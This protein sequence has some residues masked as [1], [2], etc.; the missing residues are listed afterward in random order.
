MKHCKQHWMLNTPIFKLILSCSLPILPAVFLLGAYDL[1]ETG[2]IARLCSTHLAALSFSA[3]VTTAMTGV[4]IAISIA[5]NSWICRIK[6]G[7]NQNSSSKDKDELQSNLVRSLVVA[8]CATFVLSTLLYLFSPSLYL[9]LGT[10]SSAQPAIELGMTSLVT[11]YTEIRLLGWIPLVII[12][13]INGILR[14]YGY[15]KQASLLLIT[16]MLIKSILSFNLI[17]DGRCSQLLDTGILGAGYAHLIADTLFAFISLIILFRDLG[18]QKHQVLAMKW[19]NTLKQMSVTGLNASL[20]QLYLPISIGLLT[21]FVAV[22]AEDKV[23]LLNIIF[24]IEA[25]GLFVPMVFTASIPS[26]LAAN[27]WAG[28]IDRVKALIIQGVVIIVV[29]QVLL[30]L[31]LYFNAETIA[32]EISQSSHLQQYIQQY[33]I[34]VPISFIGAGCTMLALSCL[35]AIEKSGKASTLGFAHKIVLLLLFSVIGGW[36][37]SIMG[38]LVGIALAHILSLII[39][40]KLFIR[41][42]WRKD[43]IV[44]DQPY[45]LLTL[46]N[47]K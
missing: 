13:Q 39:V 15:I 3:P 27:W 44:E 26:I 21:Y 2:L 30:A 24:R 17:G 19:Q 36:Y 29:T 8:A 6:S 46:S 7:V 11:E 5:T 1:F 47:M 37:A 41:E 28:K 22:I 20:Q 16:W 35:N 31:V 38:M 9:L 34:F 23:A 33:L 25:F 42:I 40:A 12:W 43:I 18:I 10:Q 14:S 32:A 4:A 45:R